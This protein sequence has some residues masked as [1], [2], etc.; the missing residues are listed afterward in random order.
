MKQKN[1]QRWSRPLLLT[2]LSIFMAF[3]GAS[4]AWADAYTCGFETSEG[5]AINYSYQ[6]TTEATGWSYK[7]TL[8][9]YTFSES[10]KKTGS[11]GLYCSASN[12]ANYIITP[13][14]AAGTISFYASAN[15]SKSY[16]VQFFLCTKE[17][18]ESFTIGDE[19]WGRTSMTMSS[20]TG[21]M[22]Q[23]SFNLEEDSYIAILLAN[24]AGIDDFSAPNGLAVESPYKKPASLTFTDI[25]AEGA[26]A[27]WT[28]G[29]GD[30]SE[31]G[32]DLEYKK[33]SADTWTEEH[34]IA[35]ATTSYNLTSLESN[36]SYDV[37]VRALYAESHESDWK[38]GTF[39][40][41]RAPITSYPWSE[42]FTGLSSGIPDGWDNTEGT[43]TSASYKWNYYSYDGHT[44]SPCLRF[45]SYYNS[46]NYTNF[47]KTPVM[48]YAQNAPM[49]LKFWYKNPKGG[50][51]SVFI[52]NDGGATYTQSLATGLTG[53]SAWT[54]KV[55][56]LPTDEYY[57]NVVI[58]FKGTSNCGSGDAYIYLDDVT[59]LEKANAPEM[60]YEDGDFDFGVV[61]K[62]E[63]DANIITHIFTVKNSGLAAVSN[64]S[65]TSNSADFTIGSGYATSIAA[66]EA[67]VD[68][69]M[70]FTVTLNTATAGYKT[71]IITIS[72]DGYEGEDAL[73]F[74]VSGAVMPGDA[75]TIDFNDN[76]LPANW[77]NNASYKWSFADGK[78]Y[79]T[80]AAELTTPKLQVAAGDFLVI[81]VTS[82]DDADNNY[83]EVTGSTDGSSWDVFEAKKFISRSQIPYGSYTNIVVTDIPTTVKYLKFKGFWVNVD[84]I[85]GLT[86]APVLSVT[87]GSPAAP[88]SSPAAYDFGECAANATVTYNFANT[89]GGT[90][91]ITNVAI[92]GDGAAAYST[93]WTE[94]VAPFA[95]T[96]TRSYDAGRAGAGAQE[97]VVTVTTSEGD[98]VINVTGTDKADNAPE[99]S[100]T[101]GEDPVTTGAAANFG[102]NLKAAPAAKTYTITNSGTG[103]LTG[104]IATSDDTQFTVSKTAFSLGAA[105]STTFDVALVFN[106]TYGAKA[107]TITIHPTNDGLN[108]GSHDII[109]NASASTLD[110]ETWTED[111]EGVNPLNGWDNDG[112]TVKNTAGNGG[113]T[114]LSSMMAVSA[115]GSSNSTLVTPLLIAT[116]GDKL[117]F[118][119]YFQFG[120][121]P[122][123]VEYS[124]D[125]SDWH[126]DSPLY[127]FTGSPAYEGKSLN[128]IEITA[129]ITGEFYLRFTTCYTNAID[130][131]VGFKLAP[132]KEHNAIIASNNIP[133]EGNQYV[134]YTATVTVKEKAGKADE[135]VTAELWIGTNKVATEENITLTA[136]GDKEITLSFTPATAMSG[137]AYIKVYN[138]NI[139]LT[140]ATQA[141]E[142]AAALVLDETVDPAI[143]STG[144]KPSVVVKYNAKNGWNTICMP[145]ALTSD[146]LTSIFGTGWHAYEFNNY[147][148]G[149]LGFSSTTTTF[150]AGYPYIVYVETA[151]VHAEGVKLFGVNVADDTP[152]Y[153][154]YGGVTFQG[155]YAPIA[156]GSWPT[157]AY[158]VTSDGKIAP[159][160]TSTS[161]MKGFRAYFTGITAGARL[162]FFDQATG[163]TTVIDAKELNNDGKVYNLNGQRVENAH[164]GLYIVNGRKVVVK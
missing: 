121:D 60:K 97:A 4:S 124:T 138:A 112:F 91:N 47:L 84:E 104:T 99:L 62:D 15:T 136:N 56:D 1:Y 51:F 114:Q 10:R 81:K 126:T 32:W 137:D 164:K 149:N 153:D 23:Y 135:V 16:K 70:T 65:I 34:D 100:V 45:D 17:G 108:D 110:P 39:K 145:F 48:S 79:C 69:S 117:T 21:T 73:K 116:S 160:N 44:T 119:A 142:I 6:I 102:T 9:T 92:T 22:T 50:D 106:T 80:S 118:D 115:Y 59:V 38:T 95:L 87:T 130:N 98:F 36:T 163:I 20:L 33:A 101:L 8:S 78:A 53:A 11:Y 19:V 146:I 49:Q 58:V 57:N 111:F 129:P 89:G 147:S 14:L 76:A 151:A 26:T 143:S 157:G 159:G 61:D 55:I 43:T 132:A 94:S 74:N 42:D 156:A 134:E 54:E 133:A 123:K 67:G 40:T 96:I 29:S 83:L 86:Y 41:L 30:D 35:K 131:I 31:I 85:T 148:D 139:D 105:E 158:G 82:R 68:G 125:G 162:S 144:V 3:S 113:N 141:V 161:Y 88:V 28:A 107:A 72:A 140:T 13:K 127:N 24:Q 71:G 90:I 93:N 152:N 120:N 128:E 5:W 7:G 37:R 122:M 150:Y 103:T 63:E 66:K 27:S 77:G 46:T 155:I 52:S 2:L 25:T 18:D 75:M 64:L 109:I 154:Q 12:S